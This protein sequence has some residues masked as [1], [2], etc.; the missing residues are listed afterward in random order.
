MTDLSEELRIEPIQK[1]HNIKGFDCGNE[2][3]NTYLSRFAIKNDQN[4][5]SKTFVLI[6][7]NDVV[8]G[9]YSICSASIKYNELPEELIQKL[10]KYPI[11]LARLARLAIAR[12]IKGK[13]MGARLLIDV[14]QKI[15]FAS[16]E[17]GIK[18][19]IVDALDEEAKEFYMHHGFRPLP[20]KGFTL[21]LPIETISKLF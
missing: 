3:L 7:K 9:Y 2:S 11:P 4:N 6:D 10:P 12:S 1:K 19:V 14:L 17:M 16:K 21:I 18:F 15:H 5:I 13:G 20:E 8:H